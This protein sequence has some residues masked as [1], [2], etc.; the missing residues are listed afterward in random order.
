M[1]A[2]EWH[3]I[4]G[5]EGV[6]QV[7]NGGDIKRVK[8]YGGVSLRKTR[9][10][11][12]YR[13]IFL[14][15]KGQSN[16]HFVHRLVMLAFVGECPIGKQVN[17]KNGIKDDNRL[18]NLEYVTPSENKRHAVDVLKKHIGEQNNKAK[19]TAV[20]VVEIRRLHA[21]GNT[22]IEALARM[23]KVSGVSIRAVL[24]RETWKHV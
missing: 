3:D 10:Q 1:T 23:Y 9:P 20:Q 7:S 21:E 11:N 16:R 22:K 13:L 14:R 17:H 4:P 5:Y 15:L 12:G 2:I 8:V 24:S 18:E 19:L 6:Y